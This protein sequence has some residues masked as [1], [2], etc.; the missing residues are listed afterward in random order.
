MFKADLEQADR[1]LMVRVSRLYYE[2]GR[3]QQEIA[4]ATSLSRPTVS[5]TLDRAKRAG[6]VQIRILDPAGDSHTLAQELAIRFKLR[7]VVLVDTDS[8]GK[9]SPRRRVGQKVGEYLRGLLRDGM[10]LGVT[11]GKTLQEMA[12]ALKPAHL[13]DLT[14]VQMMGGLA[15][16]EDSMETT[17]LAQEVGRIL[18]GRTVQ[19]LA[20]A[21]VAEPRARRNILGTPAIRQARDFLR[22]LDAAVVG[23]GAV[24]PHVSL[25]ERGYL[26][27]A[28]M[29]RYRRLGARGEM[30]LQFFDADGCPLD[31]LNQRVIGMPLGELSRV[32]LVVAGV[33][34]PPDKSE[35]VLAALRG[36]FIHVLITDTETARQVLDRAQAETPAA[37]R[38]GSGGRPPR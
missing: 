29:V 4:R 1:A 26:T 15:A 17:G 16:L 34:G 20:P 14:V 33:T 23:I 8:D 11:W 27:A 10:T 13:A 37:T 2:Q 36:R 18:G 9:A 35:A 5:R 38:R 25:V 3:T 32:P 24:S 6:I 30:L 19:F 21:F 31:A 28:E 12:L 22:R 7:E